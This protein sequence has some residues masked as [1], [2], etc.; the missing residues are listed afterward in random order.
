MLA[1]PCKG[2]D[3]TQNALCARSYGLSRG[4]RGG[5]W[6]LVEAVRV[7]GGNVTWDRKRLKSS[8]FKG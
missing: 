8:R 7:L 4:K 5:I 6:F 1:L 3:V 2:R